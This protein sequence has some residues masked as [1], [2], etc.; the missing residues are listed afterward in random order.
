M[1][2]A[3]LHETLLAAPGQPAAPL[4]VIQPSGET[5]K[6]TLIHEPCRDELLSGA[7]LR[8]PDHAWVSGQVSLIAEGLVHL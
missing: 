8:F 1:A 7:V 2:M 6:V 5:V 3:L 4:S